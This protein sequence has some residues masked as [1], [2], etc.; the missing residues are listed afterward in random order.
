MN[1]P[2]TRR[3]GL[4]L[5]VLLCSGAAVAKD[6]AGKKSWRPDSELNDR[7]SVRAGFYFVGYDSFARA[8][9]AFLLGTLLDLEQ[10]LGLETRQQIL[11][12][13]LYYRFTP[14]SRL[15]VGVFRFRRSATF[16]NEQEF[17]WGENV[18]PAGVQI[19]TTLHIDH[20]T[21]TYRYAVVH[22]EQ[23]EMGL[24]VGFSFL[25]IATDLFAVA[26]GGGS[27]GELEEDVGLIA[28]IPVL[29]FYGSA[30]VT[31]RLCVTFAGEFFKL[32]YH[33]FAGTVSEVSLGFDY[34]A[35]RHWGFGFGYSTERIDFTAKNVNGIDLAVDL[36]TAGYQVYA[37][38]VAGKGKQ[39]SP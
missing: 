16:I 18:F 9:S 3:I 39:P 6:A 29:G 38:F 8:S 31:K 1:R 23:A 13:S 15:D 20:Y 10:S 21:I 36:Q 26:G 17:V 33:D 24:S 14:L 34:Y 27:S 5:S 25:D 30:R 2:I 19:D 28:P 37:I 7:I 11:R 35:H 32:S 12:S 4:L 22:N